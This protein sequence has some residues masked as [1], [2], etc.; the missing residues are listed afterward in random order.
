MSALA[1]AVAVI[2]ELIRLARLACGTLPKVA[3]VLLSGQ[4]NVLARQPY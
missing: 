1:L 3:K 4:A 2:L